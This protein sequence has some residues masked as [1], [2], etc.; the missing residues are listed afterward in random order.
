MQH[1]L[2]TEQPPA[3]LSMSP[4][5][6]QNP[7]CAALGLPLLSASYLIRTRSQLWPPLRLCILDL[8]QGKSGLGHSTSCHCFSSIIMKI[9][10][11]GQDC[12]CH[13]RGR[14]NDEVLASS[15]SSAQQRAQLAAEPWTNQ[16]AQQII[17]SVSGT[18]TPVG[19]QS[20][21]PME[22]YPFPAV[23]SSV[24]FSNMVTWAVACIPR[25]QGFEL[26]PL[27]MNLLCHKA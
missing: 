11:C 14:Y 19:P 15:A 23:C 13:C 8:Y 5:G 6:L 17:T 9:G 16:E 27:H 24:A 25:C 20:L 2:L 3:S 26:V 18:Q 21:E 1:I 22:A 10:R 7:S 12:D 4:S